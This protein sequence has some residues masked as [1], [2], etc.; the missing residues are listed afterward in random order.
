[1]ESNR[2][3]SLNY[4]F[5][6]PLDKQYKD[7]YFGSLSNTVSWYIF[8]KNNQFMAEIKKLWVDE[9]SPKSEIYQWVYFD[10]TEMHPLKFKE[11]DVTEDVNFREFEEGA[12]AFN[13]KRA[14]FNYTPGKFTVKLEVVDPKDISEQNFKIIADY[15]QK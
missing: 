1:M 8:E 11:M 4:Y 2:S 5:K 3:F 14:S 15:L 7:T 12:M 9:N 13:D 6:G 10:G